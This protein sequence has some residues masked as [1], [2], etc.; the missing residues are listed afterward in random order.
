MNQLLG[1]IWINQDA[2]PTYTSYQFRQLGD[3]QALSWRSVADKSK[4]LF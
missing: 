3:S 4:R 1:R 2:R